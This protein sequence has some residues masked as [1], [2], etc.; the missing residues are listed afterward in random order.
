MSI[1]SWTPESEVQ[2]LAIDR[3]FLRR[4]INLS[5]QE[6]LADLGQQLS[7]EEQQRYAPL[8]MVE[9]AKW[10]EAIADFSDD[11]LL[12][13]IRFFTLAEAQLS[14][15]EAGNESPVIWINKALRRRG[16]R[17]SKEMLLWIKANSDNQYLPNG[18]L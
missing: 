14:G 3:D 17:L 2:Q 5:E 4:C 16:G 11:E 12:H 13:L 9:R 15:W 7:T 18:G 8:M 10:D 6:Q 1:G